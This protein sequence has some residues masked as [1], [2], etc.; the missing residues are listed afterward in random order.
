MS[1]TTKTGDN[2][3]TRLSSGE[4]VSKRS[5]RIAA[6][7]DIDELVS[8]LGVTSA[9]LK[10]V[11]N[12][13]YVYD[14]IIHMQRRLFDVASEIATLE[15]KLNNLPN[16]ITVDVIKEIDEKRIKLESSIELPQGFVLPGVNILSANLDMCRAISRRCERSIVEIYNE[17]FINNQNMLV[18]MNRLSDFLYLLARYSERNS[19]R[20]VK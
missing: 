14:E 19:Y 2:G 12:D 1:I 17:G 13:Q 5:K 20:L 18:W 16:R 3:S 8:M 6:C 11:S 4:T 9:N 10:L 7:G 15:P